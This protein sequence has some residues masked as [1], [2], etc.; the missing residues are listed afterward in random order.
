MSG[1]RKSAFKRPRAAKGK[2]NAAKALASMSGPRSMSSAVRTSRPVFSVDANKR[3]GP[4][5][6][7]S[8]ARPNNQRVTMRY[9]DRCSLNAGT[10]TGAIQA[11][12]ANSIFDPDSTGTGHQPYGRDTWAT[13][14]NH[15]TVIGSKIQVKGY[16]SPTTEN[17]GA[18]VII[19]LSLDDAALSAF[20]APGG[21]Y[22]CEGGNVA[23]DLADT[24]NVGRQPVRLKKSFV[25]SSFF[26]KEAPED[27][28]QLGAAMGSNPAEVAFFNLAVTGNDGGEPAAMEF[29]VTIDYDVILSEPTLLTPS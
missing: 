5:T 10:A 29:L 6:T 28:D 7:L 4:P 12:R 27:N 25:S 23:Y 21:I 19:S 17:F 20:V 18:P 2:W 8:M 3:F 16:S 13:M 15:Y 1:I 9:V 11:Y 22:R 24:G 14:F 26:S